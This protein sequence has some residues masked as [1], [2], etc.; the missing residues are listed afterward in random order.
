MAAAFAALFVAA[1][2][3]ACRGPSAVLAI[4]HSELPASLPAGHVAIE[5]A[6]PDTLTDRDFRRSGGEARILRVVRGDIP[7]D[8][9]YVSSENSRTSCDY[10]FGNGRAGFLVG[11]LS[12]MDG[13]LAIVPVRVARRN[14]FRMI[15]Q[16]G[17]RPGPT[18][19]QSAADSKPR[20]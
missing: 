14:G 6:F 12:R 10:A 4:I 8:T 3:T 17:T 18:P 16:Q 11:R 19:T 7:G 9:I 5:V 13:R 15:D 1:P 2:A 20:P